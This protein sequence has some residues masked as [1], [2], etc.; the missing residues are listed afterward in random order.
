MPKEK[1]LIG[2]E[3]KGLVKIRLERPKIGFVDPTE[4]VVMSASGAIC[5]VLEIS[6]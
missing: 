1:N 4:R 5:Q 3:K 6:T 2:M